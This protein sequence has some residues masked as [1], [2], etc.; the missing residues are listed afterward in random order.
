[1]KKISVSLTM[2]LFVA[3]LTTS[4]MAQPGGGR[5][6]GA[7]GRGFGGGGMMMDNP[8]V[9]RELGL[10]AE[11]QEKIRTITQEAF[12]NM[13]PGQGRGQGGMRPT[14]EEMQ[15]RR[16]ELEKRFDELQVKFDEILTAEQVVKHKE[17]QFKM[18]GGLENNAIGVR[19][20]AALDLTD[21]QKKQITA[22]EEERTRS[23]VPPP[24]DANQSREERRAAMEE[25]RTKREADNK[26]YVEKVKKILTADQ[27]AKAEKLTA[28][29]QKLREE[30]RQNRG[31][32]RGQGQNRRQGGVAAPPMQRGQGAYQPG[33][34]SWR[35]GMGAPG[36]NREERR[37]FPQTEAQKAEVPKAEV[38]KAEN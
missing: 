37:A 2:V 20:M 27:L 28:E 19:S 23:F 17:L 13:Q 16:A 18:T 25:L 3:V 15:Q 14:A 7:G 22:L 6:A 34:E 4:V 35:P 33:D 5:G 30:M 12:Q 38:P 32:N 21:D 24:F 31:Q 8:V 1:M 29:G 10:S 9:I 36:V 26:A 11:Q